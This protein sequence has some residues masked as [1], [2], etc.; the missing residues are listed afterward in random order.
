[1]IK[2]MHMVLDKYIQQAKMNDFDY[3]IIENEQMPFFQIHVGEY[4]VFIEDNREIPHLFI[5][6]ARRLVTDTITGHQWAVTKTE[7]HALCLLGTKYLD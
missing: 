4:F 5:K 6:D 3:I 7:K 2:A 1:M